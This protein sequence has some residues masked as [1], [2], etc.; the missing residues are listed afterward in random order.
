MFK[1]TVIHKIFSEL[2]LEEDADQSPIWKVSWMLKKASMRK[3]SLKSLEP[4][5]NEVLR[6]ANYPNPVFHE[7]WFLTI[8]PF[9]GIPV[10]IAKVPS[11][12][13]AGVFFEDFH[14]Q[15]NI[16]FFDTQ[17]PLHAFALLYWR[18]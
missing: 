18:L 2:L 1:K 14:G 17:L 7:M 8:D 9:V 15:E 4:R 11:D 16:Q 13:T 3:N 12:N 10:F 5:W 6:V